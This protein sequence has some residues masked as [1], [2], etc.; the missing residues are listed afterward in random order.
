[1]L[2]SSL[3]HLAQTSVELGHHYCGTF[4][5]KKIHVEKYHTEIVQSYV[6]EQK[7]YVLRHEYQASTCLTVPVYSR[8]TIG[9]QIMIKIKNCFG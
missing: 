7:H 9:M 6:K 1:M 4:R 3:K 8:S 2:D 5:V